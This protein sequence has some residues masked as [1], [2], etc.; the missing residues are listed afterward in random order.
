MSIAYIDTVKNVKKEK[1]RSRALVVDSIRIP[2]RIAALVL[3]KKGEERA[4]K[5]IKHVDSC[6][7]SYRR[8]RLLL[9]D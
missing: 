9:V 4:W 5:V 1:E 8:D 2:R 6:A 7:R 3:L